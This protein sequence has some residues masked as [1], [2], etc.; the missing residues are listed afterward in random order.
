MK[1][2]TSLKLSV[3]ALAI[4]A[5][6]SAIADESASSFTEAM[7]GGDVSLSFRY[8][9][10]YVDQDD[11]SD[12]ANASTNRTRLN[13]KTLGFKG[14][15]GFIEFDDNSQVIKSD[16]NTGKSGNNNTKYPVVADDTYTEVNQAYIDFAAPMDTLA[17]GGIQRINIDNQRFVGGAAWRQNEQ[18]FEAFTLVNTAIQDTTVTLSYITN[19]NTVFGTNINNKEHQVVNIHN[20]SLSFG[21]ISAYAYILKNF[22]D[23]YGARFAGKTDLEELS[24]VYAAEFAY[25]DSDV[26][27]NSDKDANYYLAEFGGVMSGI[28]AKIGY[29]VQ[30]SD[31]G[32]YSFSTPIGTNHKFNGWAD[33]F[34]TTPDDGLEDLYL[35]LSTKILGPEIGLIYHN[36]ESNEGSTNYGDE[37]DFIISQDFAENYNVLL[38]A[39]AYNSDDFSDDTKKVWF[40]LSAKF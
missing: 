39:A 27:D 2:R 18:T 21:S 31:N 26:P 28:E 20:K 14:F 10:T 12:K 36:F 1:K 15:T 16:A 6:S 29:E 7:T 13:Y 23:T 22:S 11:I 5:S 8:R 38:K 3:L 9:Y 37:V 32:D 17:R 25:Q 35:S 40:Q 24:L 4:S 33:K 30:E 19:I 34:L